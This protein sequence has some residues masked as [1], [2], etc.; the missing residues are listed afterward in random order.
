MGR[1]RKGTH[2]VATAER[3][4]AAAA[5]EFARAGF[6][7]GRLEDIAAQAGITR[8]S[9]LYHWGSKEALHAAVVHAAFA[10]LGEALALA[11]QTEGEFGA[12]LDAL[13]DAFL[14]FL[15]TNP[16]VAP[17]ILREVLDHGGPGHRL[18]AQ[19]VAPVLSQVERFV[20]AAGRGRVRAR[21]PV[22]AV[23]MQVAASALLRAAAG[24]LGPALWGPMDRT[25]ELARR[26]VLE[27]E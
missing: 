13:I 18:L 5:R 19:E 14:G 11:M 8:A 24:E 21:L 20:R 26:L 17:L 25:R 27:E 23:L 12:R 22:R 2:D 3:S 9:L 16:E 7:A 15:S 1:P 10:R 4:L 6:H